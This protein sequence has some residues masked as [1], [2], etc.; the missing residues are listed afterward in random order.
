MTT[1]LDCIDRY[2]TFPTL[3]KVLLGSPVLEGVGMLVTERK[4]LK[5]QKFPLESRVGEVGTRA[6]CKNTFL[7]IRQAVFL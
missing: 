4:R 6:M 3:Q 2:R 1:V 5:I 7:S